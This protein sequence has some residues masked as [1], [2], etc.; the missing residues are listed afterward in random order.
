LVAGECHHVCQLAGNALHAAIG[1][2]LDSGFGREQSP[3]DLDTIADMHK[4]VL[5]LEKRG[6]GQDDISR[7]MHGNWMR[8][9]QRVLDCWMHAAAESPLF[10]A[11]QFSVTRNLFVG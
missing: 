11:G 6:Y 3:S 7:V 1:S 5:I 9:L 2:D 4:I 10:P 8:L